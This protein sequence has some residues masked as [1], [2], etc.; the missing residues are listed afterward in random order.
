M[1]DRPRASREDRAEGPAW[2]GRELSGCVH[3]VQVCQAGLLFP[4]LKLAMARRRMEHQK[5]QTRPLSQALVL[6]PDQNS[7]WHSPGH[8]DNVCRLSKAGIWGR[9][10]G[11]QPGGRGG[12]WSQDSRETGDR[13]GQGAFGLPGASASRSSPPPPPP[14]PKPAHVPLSSLHPSRQ[15]RRA[16]SRLIS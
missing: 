10:G 12:N 3:I 13:R 8:S 7:A 15:Q 1:G 4:K 11:G 2:V 5:E 14:A 16:T 6:L 9:A